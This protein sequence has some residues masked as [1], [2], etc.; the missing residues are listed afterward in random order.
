MTIFGRVLRT[1]RTW[2]SS[3]PLRQTL[4]PNPPP[5]AISPDLPFPP[6]RSATEIEFVKDGSWSPRE[7]DA[8]VSTFGLKLAGAKVEPDERQKNDFATLVC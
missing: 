2:R 1:A 4:S 5:R 3:A 7:L 8:L 6:R